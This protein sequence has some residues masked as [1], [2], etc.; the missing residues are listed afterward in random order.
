MFNADNYFDPTKI[1]NDCYNNSIIIKNAFP[2]T[3]AGKGVLCVAKTVK[4]KVKLGV[5]WLGLAWLGL[6]EMCHSFTPTIYL[7]YP[8]TKTFYRRGLWGFVGLLGYRVN[9]KNPPFLFS[10]VLHFNVE[11]AL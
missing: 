7:K 1:C 6:Q 4:L 11:C 2:G 3:L 5:F 8:K 10:Q 9:P